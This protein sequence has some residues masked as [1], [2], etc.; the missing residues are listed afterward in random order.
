MNWKTFYALLARDAHVAR[1]NLGP[2]LLQN[3]LQPLLFT[4]VFGKVMTG[5]GMM[6]ASYKNML[7]PGVMAI[8]MVM[9]GVQA[10]A[11][12]LITE[13]Q[14]TREIEDRLL[15]PIEVGWLAVAKIVTGMIQAMAAGLVVIPAAW[16][17]M[18]SGVTL[19]F[20][21]PVEFLL[22]AL[23]VAGFSS[24]GGLA[25]GCSVG[26]TQI[27]L[28]FSLVLAP[29]MMFGCAYYPWSA[30]ESFPLLHIAVL[31]NPLVYASEG[32]RGALVPQVPHM[33]TLVVIGALTAIDLCLLFL[34]LK[35][36]RQK[37]VS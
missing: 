10:V 21:H 29:M 30:L 15:A 16:L 22:V 37:A 9:A 35:K 6:P 14:F 36:F 17:I 13:F 3:L 19:D 7:L 32:L 26:Q 8:S 12:P 11:M 27:G 23:L 2:T 33:N 31:V 24:T 20:T 25:L 18:G 28:M 5:S 4:F 1:R 34:G